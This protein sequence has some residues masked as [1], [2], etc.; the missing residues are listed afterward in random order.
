MSA[1]MYW[2]ALTLAATS[3][4]WAP[5]VLNRIAVRGLIGTVRNPSV[6]DAPLADWAQRAQKAHANAV[7]NLVVFAP[8]VLAIQVQARGDSVTTTACALYFY[9]RLAHYILYTLGIP[10]LRTVAFFGGWAGITILVARLLGV[11]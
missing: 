3:L 7:E 8:A 4:F 6:N 1:E 5:Y 2:L 9:S 10:W 11:L